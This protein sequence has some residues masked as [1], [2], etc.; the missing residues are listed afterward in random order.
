M[1]QGLGPGGQR[2]SPYPRPRFW[3]DLDDRWGSRRKDQP[4]RWLRGVLPQTWGV[5]G[6]GT[7][8][9]AQGL[10]RAWEPRQTFAGEFL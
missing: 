7:C 5:G 1:G 8:S 2:R 4:A 10:E 6:P 3:R 9:T